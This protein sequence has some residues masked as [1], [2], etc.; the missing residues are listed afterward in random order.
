[1]GAMFQ[2]CKLLKI[3]DISN[4]N[5]SKVYNMECMFNE[6]TNLKEIKG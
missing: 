1:M 6:S 3:L 5:T 4:F 2:G